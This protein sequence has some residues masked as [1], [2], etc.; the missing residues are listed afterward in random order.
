VGLAEQLKSVGYLLV[1]FQEERR[2]QSVFEDD[3][4]F[5]LNR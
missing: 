5:R 3:D 1:R 2:V 4:P